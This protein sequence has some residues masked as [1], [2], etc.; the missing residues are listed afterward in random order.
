M[1]VKEK[2][3]YKVS[4][5]SLADWLETQPDKWW[6]VD[7]DPLLTS[8]VDFPCPSDE[9]APVIRR[10]G[11]DLLIQDQNANSAAHGQGIA[12]NELDKLADTSNRKR[13]K[14]FRLCWVGSD[15]DWLLLEDEA[16]AAT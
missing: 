8:T 16:M 9:L 12:P 10:V 13:R 15:V 1:A 2:P 5:K 11:T 6:S 3:H 7:G 14:I 4:A